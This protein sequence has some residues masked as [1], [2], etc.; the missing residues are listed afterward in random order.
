MTLKIK[1][2]LVVASF[3]LPLFA[4]M[5]ADDFSGH[6]YGS[7][8][9]KGG[10]FY[11][12]FLRWGNEEAFWG[13]YFN[14]SKGKTEFSDYYPKDP[15]KEKKYKVF[16]YPFKVATF[17][18][19]RIF[20]ARFGD[21]RE[22]EVTGGK[23]ASVT[24]KSG[25]VYH[26]DGYAN[27]V[28]A[29]IIILDRDFGAIKIPWRRIDKIVFKE[30]PE[31][32]SHDRGQRLYGTVETLKRTFKGYIQWDK[33]ECL[34]I[35]KLDG[36]T[37]DGTVSLLMGAIDKITKE[38]DHSCRVLLKDTRELTLTNHGDVTKRNRGIYVE[39][40]RYGRVLIPWS[41]FKNVI[42]QST[43]NSGP[44][45]RSYVDNGDI[46]ARITTQGGETHEGRL[47]FDLDEQEKW[48]LLNGKADHINFDVPFALIA[49]IKPN[50]SSS[51]IVLKNGQEL[52]L[53][54]KTDVDRN[55]TGILVWQGEDEDP[56]YLPWKSVAN[57]AIL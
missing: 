45:Y 36:Q 19:Q 57:I 53:A 4:T 52:T 17:G 54:G 37:E 56:R 51:L 11:E 3:G 39:D 5:D 28:G 9:V 22:I 15:P 40:D 41:Q 18:V 16:N 21:I 23:S 42:F 43:R 34:T 1:L 30:V 14:S 32:A 12:G 20:T 31:G 38:G 13:D 8:Q 44:P 48:E 33:Q 7:V 47:V 55:N 6:L 49:S 46:H 27:D 50:G 10:K 29:E 25:K 26:V 35:D 2:A 24:M